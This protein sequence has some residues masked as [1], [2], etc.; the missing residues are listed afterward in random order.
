VAELFSSDG[1]VL[2]RCAI[3][4]LR[5]IIGWHI[6]RPAYHRKFL[7]IGPM[8]R[9]SPGVPLQISFHGS[10]G[11]FS[12]RGAIANFFSWIRWQIFQPECHCKFLFIDL[13]ANSLPSVPFQTYFFYQMVNVSPDV[14]SQIYF[15]I[16]KGKKFPYPCRYGCRY[17]QSGSAFREGHGRA[18]AQG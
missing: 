5:F 6:F 15:A 3:A 16:L 1:T 4:N 9:F 8:V 13:M 14:P 11:K 2:A 17:R 7:F 18:A 12:S 10:D